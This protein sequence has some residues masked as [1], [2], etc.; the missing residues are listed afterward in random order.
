MLLLFDQEFPIFK[1]T[2][3][4]IKVEENEA[5]INYALQKRKVKV[6]ETGLSFGVDGFV[7]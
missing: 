4:T 1:C 7:Q 6:V 3:Y 5:V 2:F